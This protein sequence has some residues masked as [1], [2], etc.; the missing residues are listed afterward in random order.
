MGMGPVPIYKRARYLYRL[1]IVLGSNK[2]LY[3]WVIESFAVRL[4]HSSG[5]TQNLCFLVTVH[6]L[7]A[8]ENGG[9]RPSNDGQG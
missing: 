1:E 7:W 3:L 5:F 9:Y 8:G 6:R 2:S 4:P